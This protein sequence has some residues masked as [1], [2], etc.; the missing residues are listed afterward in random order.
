[1]YQAF[2]IIICYYK[3]KVEEKSW[4]DIKKELNIEISPH[5]LGKIIELIDGK[6]NTSLEDLRSFGIKDYIEKMERELD[7]K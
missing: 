2:L 4:D 3:K 1:M 6:I 5:T 7:V